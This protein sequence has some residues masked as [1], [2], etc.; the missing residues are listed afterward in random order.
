VFSLQWKRPNWSAGSKRQI[1][2]LR[3]LAGKTLKYFYSYFISSR[4]RAE[5]GMEPPHFEQVKK[6]HQ[7]FMSTGSLTNGHGGSGWL[8]AHSNGGG[9]NDGQHGRMD[10]TDNSFGLEAE[11]QLK[12]GGLH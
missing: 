10:A 3:R 12:M 6:W 1:H 5:F 11:E 4:Y 9:G 2:L 7:R 8:E